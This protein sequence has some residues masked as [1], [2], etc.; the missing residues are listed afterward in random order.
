MCIFFL[1]FLY[2]KNETSTRKKTHGLDKL[3]NLISFRTAGGGLKIPFVNSA[4][5]VIIIFFIS[6]FPVLS[7]Y[8]NAKQPGTILYVFCWEQFCKERERELKKREREKRITC[9]AI[10]RAFALSNRN[11][12]Q[13][14]NVPM[15]DN[16]NLLLR[17]LTLF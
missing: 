7:R 1:L 16:A 14:R 12:I 3:K 5:V 6:D 17:Y 9:L 10:S 8:K 15:V 13:A 2:V 4:T 11:T